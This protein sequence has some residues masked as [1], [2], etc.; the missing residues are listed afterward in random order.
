LGRLLVNQAVSQRPELLF[1]SPRFLFPADTG[2]AIRTSEILRGMRGGTFRIRLLSPA[3]G[4]EPQRYAAQ[5][6]EIADTWETWPTTPKRGT[7][8]LHRAP[9]LVSSLPVPIASDASDQGRRLVA[10]ALA[11]RPDVV[12][13]DFLHSVVLA[14]A[15]LEVPAV[16]FTHNVEAEIFQRNLEHARHVWGRL[17]WRDQLKKMRRFESAALRRF[18]RVVAVSARDAALFQSDYGRDDIDV[19]PTG[20]NLEQFSYVAPAPNNRVTFTGSM[21]WLANIDAIT[22]FRDEVWP[23]VVSR[24]PQATMTVV[25]RNP[26]HD[27][28]RAAPANWTFTGRVDDIRP[29]VHGSAAFVI[30]M[31]IGGGTRIKAFEAMAMG[32]PVVSTA[33]GVEGLDVQPCKHFLLADSAQ[34]FAAALLALLE[35]PQQGRELSEQARSHVQAHYSNHAV[36][37][38]FEWICERARAA[39]MLSS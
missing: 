27:M 1:I 36:A 34:E 2:G 19:I 9:L 37:R 29:H 26:P 11:R 24:R 38:T 32:V 39:P 28:V 15:S 23:Q 10:G 20:V 17:L 3:T 7:L 4:D 31:R 13:F 18:S 35:R 22:W 12:V 6:G 21:D 5:L 30:P 14:P 25:G 8:S 16:L 33:V